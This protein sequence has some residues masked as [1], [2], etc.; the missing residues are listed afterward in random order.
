MKDS[1]RATASEWLTSGDTAAQA[2][3]ALEAGKTVGAAIYRE[4]NEDRVLAIAG[5]VVFYALLALFPA[6]TAFVSIYGLFTDPA[7]VTNHL[8]LLQD[9]MPSGAFGIFET[10]ATR[11]AEGGATQLGVTS[12]IAL[13]AAIWFANS[14]TKGIMDA[15]NV[16]YGEKETRGFLEYNLTA[17]LLTLGTMAAL[18]LVVGA[19]I[20]VPLLLAA[21]GVDSSLG[22][23]EFLRW[24]LLLLLVLTGLA[25]FYRFGPNRSEPRWTWLS[26]GATTATVA[27]LAASAL[28]SWYLSNFANYNAVY[29]SLGAV[30]A[31]MM[32]MWISTI[33]VL[34][35]AELDSQ[36][37][38]Y[39]RSQS[40]DAEE[41]RK[42]A[43]KQ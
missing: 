25:V 11:A 22:W 33:V 13:L 10:Q 3:K 23:L 31:L 17:L 21:F 8:S 15:L 37:A 38:A 6:I 28:F 5:G 30:I 20:V 19:V 32:W 7:T 27:W 41:D 43:E 18:L 34:L 29:G 4:F 14:G 16:V 2:R 1:S 40:G 36:I 9:V 35:G 39:K 26:A 12:I 24:P 42:S